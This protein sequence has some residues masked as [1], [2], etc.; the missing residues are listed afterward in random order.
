MTEYEEHFSSY[1]GKVD[2]LVLWVRLFGCRPGD[3]DISQGRT[4]AAAAGIETALQELGE[5]FGERIGL[6][7]LSDPDYKASEALLEKVRRKLLAAAMVDRASQRAACVSALSDTAPGHGV[8]L[9]AIMA[10]TG[11]VQAVVRSLL[12]ASIAESLE[13][14]P[15]A[16]SPCPLS[17]VH[18]R[19]QITVQISS[20]AKMRADLEVRLDA[21]MKDLLSRARSNSTPGVLWF[22]AQADTPGFLALLDQDGRERLNYMLKHVGDKVDDGVGIDEALPRTP[23]RRMF[24]H[25]LMTSALD[26]LTDELASYG[27]ER[28]DAREN[29]PIRFIG[30]YR[31]I[32]ALQIVTH[33]LF[34]DKDLLLEA[35]CHDMLFEFVELQH[36][37]LSPSAPDF[38][39]LPHAQDISDRLVKCFRSADATITE[40]EALRDGKALPE[41][42]NLGEIHEFET[43]DE[44]AFGDIRKKLHARFGPIRAASS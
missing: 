16:A 4:S 10:Q 21:T 41:S 17:I 18:G 31:A 27:L 30:R 9:V 12:G 28:Q 5:N 23:L 13:T 6:P 39:I 19:P 40:G 35:M 15:D 24:I 36:P 8:G 43:L 26:Y 22:E 38:A 1:V 11:H 7:E 29:D 33:R 2:P 34:G 20:K 3:T 37:E 14:F 44:V 25:E 42:S 32:S